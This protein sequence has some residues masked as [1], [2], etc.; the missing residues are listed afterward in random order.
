M[1]FKQNSNAQVQNKALFPPG[2][3]E[4][5][6]AAATPG[7]EE[8]RKYREALLKCITQRGKGGRGTPR[9]TEIAAGSVY[10][11]TST[12]SGNSGQY[13]WGE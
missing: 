10:G 8:M 12:T 6:G 13:I 5:T 7:R 4:V 2:E 1:N 11:G 3:G 9:N